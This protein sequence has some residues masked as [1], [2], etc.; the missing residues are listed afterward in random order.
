MRIVFPLMNKAY[1]NPCTRCGTERVIIR[2]WEEKIGGSIITNTQTACPDV[3]CQRVV[4]REIKKQREKNAALRLRSE[5]RALQRKA[6]K[7]AARLAK[8]Q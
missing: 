3:A 2:I 1:R 5:Q 8:N 6:E 4:N 7:Y